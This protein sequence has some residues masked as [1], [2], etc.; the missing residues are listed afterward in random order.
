MGL[1]VRILALTWALTYWLVFA[2]I[3][4]SVTVICCASFFQSTSGTLL[5]AILMLF[6]TSELAFGMMVRSFCVYT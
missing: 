6:T 4:A 1:D 3:A 5:F 2:I